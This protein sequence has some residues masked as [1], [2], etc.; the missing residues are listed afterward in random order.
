MLQQM[1][2]FY[3]PKAEVIP[4]CFSVLKKIKTFEDLTIGL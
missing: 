1:Y 2:F 3:L 4:D